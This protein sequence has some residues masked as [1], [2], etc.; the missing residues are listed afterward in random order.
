MRVDNV[1]VIDHLEVDFEAGLNLLT[2]ET[3][4]GKSILIDALGLV[5]GNRASSELVRTGA[6]SAVVEAGFEMDPVP[7]LLGARLQ[8]AG[9]EPEPELVIRREITKAG[10]GRIVVNG[11]SS[12]RVKQMLTTEGS[13]DPA[14]AVAVR[15]ID[16]KLVPRT[17]RW[18]EREEESA[19]HLGTAGD[20]GWQIGMRHTFR[21]R[22][23]DPRARLRSAS[24]HDRTRR[25]QGSSGRRRKAAQ[26]GQS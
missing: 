2:G 14:F 16:G 8:N 25:L 21:H 18:N 22:P 13:F 6:E 20:H 10:R 4:A 5:L 11:V 17:F 9:I 19:Y 3:G 1:A 7:E 12:S 23:P 24:I 15:H 26:E